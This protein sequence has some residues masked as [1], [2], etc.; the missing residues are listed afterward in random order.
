MTK[1]PFLIAYKL[2][3]ALLGFSA[4]VTEIVVLLER[5]TF[6][7]V[8]FF[9]FF[10][11]QVNILVCIVFLL[12]AI[13]IAANKAKKLDTLRT[14][15]TVFILIVG[16]GFALLLAGLEGVALTAAPWD[17]TVLHYIIPVAVLLDFFIDRPQSRQRF[18]KLLIWLLYP[19]AYFAYTMIRGAIVG[20]Y[21]YPF[22]N[23]NNS[24]YAE[25]AVAVAGLF[26]LGIIFFAI[27]AKLSSK[28]KLTA[29]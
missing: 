17:N 10:T 4:I 15:T 3:F 21:P 12:S 2:L 26:I 19:L 5:G 25:I 29:K 9:S 23:P 22:L 28:K 6:N 14:A 18:K 11:I 13:F 20:W 1:K 16:I 27:A 7:V 24:T 8:N